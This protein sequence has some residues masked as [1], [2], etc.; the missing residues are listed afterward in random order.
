M[1][2]SEFFTTEAGSAEIGGCTS[3]CSEYSICTETTSGLLCV[4]APGYHGDG[5]IC[6]EDEREN[7]IDEPPPQPSCLVGTCWCPQGWELV[8]SVC[9]PKE[10]IDENFPGNY[11][12]SNQNQQGKSIFLLRL[13]WFD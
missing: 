7:P 6:I 8:Q 3:N 4:C 13:W 2:Q 12:D 10:Q 5:Y 9:V 1:T 11:E